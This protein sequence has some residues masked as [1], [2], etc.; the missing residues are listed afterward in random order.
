MY[1]YLGHTLADRIKLI[2]RYLLL[3][4]LLASDSNLRKKLLWDEFEWAFMRDLPIQMASFE[5]INE[6]DI[7][8][9]Q[10]G[11][12]TEDANY[13]DK[14]IVG[15]YSPVGFRFERIHLLSRVNPFLEYSL[16]KTVSDLYQSDTTYLDVLARTRKNH[17]EAII[18]RKVKSGIETE[19]DM[20]FVMWKKEKILIQNKGLKIRLV[21]RWNREMFN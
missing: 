1:L 5:R 6:F 21:E 19:P 8:F 20:Q 17:L 3:L 14:Y 2:V 10:A 13:A 7:A 16:V 4:C 9:Q 12:Y 11:T 15:I 18:Y